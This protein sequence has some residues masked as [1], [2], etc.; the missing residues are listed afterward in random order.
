MFTETLET[1]SALGAP[2][3]FSLLEVCE[4]F[5]ESLLSKLE[6][7]KGFEAVL[8]NTKNCNVRKKKAQT[9]SNLPMKISAQA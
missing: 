1:P 9:I 3:C 4:L 5:A 6:R 2:K 8:G 7:V